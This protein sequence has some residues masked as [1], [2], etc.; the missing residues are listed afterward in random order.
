M[1]PLSEPPLVPG[2]SV[3]IVA[4]LS[5]LVSLGVLA[6]V[7]VLLAFLMSVVPHLMDGFSSSR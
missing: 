6:A 2:R 7:V 4:W 3:K 5:V 1:Q